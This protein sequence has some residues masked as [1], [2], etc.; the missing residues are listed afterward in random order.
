MSERVPKKQLWSKL[1]RL[2]INGLA[3]SVIRAL[4]PEFPDNK[5]FDHSI[6]DFRL[7]IY[8]V[9]H[10]SLDPALALYS[11]TC[12]HLL[13]AIL[14]FTLCFVHQCVFYIGQGAFLGPAWT[15]LVHCFVVPTCLPLSSN[16][17][18]ASSRKPVFV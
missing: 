8:L 6:C 9:L 13:T 5:P 17:S 11:V 2:T 7:T 1:R 10:V 16:L 15:P 12:L 18:H 4:K 3:S 14:S